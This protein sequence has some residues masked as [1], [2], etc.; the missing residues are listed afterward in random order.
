[1]ELKDKIIRRKVQELKYY[2]DNPR[3]HSIKQIEDLSKQIDLVGF[4]QPI[5]IDENNQVLVGNGRLEAADKLSMD[6][7]S[8]IVYTNEDIK[9]IAKLK[10]TTPENI[11]KQMIIADN[12][13]NDNSGWDDDTLGDW[14]NELTEANLDTYFDPNEMTEIWD[15]EKLSDSDY[16]KKIEVP[17]YE[18]SDTKP[19]EN[20]LY[21]NTKTKELIKLINNLNIDDKQKEFLISAASRLIVFNYDKIADYYAH[22]DKEV[23]DI[24]EK[25]ALIL[26]DYD[27]AISNGFVR[28][29][30]EIAK[31]LEEEDGE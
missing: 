30:K 25:M 24:M 12:K 31:V 21:D 6:E 16:T 1:M 9:K 18:P 4:N 10:N 29:T 17:T 5:I 2:P 28:M 7:I 11:K 8:C 13:L 15:D 26:I 19:T 14:L 3:K 27:K 22:S 20:Q 23:Q